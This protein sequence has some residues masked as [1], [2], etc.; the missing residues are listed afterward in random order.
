MVKVV[1]GELSSPGTLAPG[2]LEVV[3]EEELPTREVLLAYYAQVEKA[4]RR[5]GGHNKLAGKYKQLQ[6][7]ITKRFSMSQREMAK[8]LHALC[9]MDHLPRDNQPRTIRELDQQEHFVAISAHAELLWSTVGATTRGVK[10]GG[11]AAPMKS[12]AAGRGGGGGYGAAGGGGFATSGGRGYAGAGGGG[13]FGRGGGSSVS[14]RRAMYADITCHGCGG[15]G[16]VVRECPSPQKPGVQRGGGM[17]KRGGGGRGG[18]R[19]S[20]GDDGG[21]GGGL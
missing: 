7:V 18:G 4:L 10:A 6:E 15:R 1:P 9:D 17:L 19:G 12:G 5:L 14:P 13:S 16:H 8:H 3:M 11:G 2:E 20:G 21:G